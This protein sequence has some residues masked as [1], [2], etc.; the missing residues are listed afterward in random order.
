MFSKM[1]QH[2]EIRSFVLVRF[3]N[4]FQEKKTE[5]RTTLCVKGATEFTTMSFSS[6]Q[7]TK[8]TCSR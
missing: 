2:M 3:Q 8:S 1:H 5:R 4:L 6:V 7:Q